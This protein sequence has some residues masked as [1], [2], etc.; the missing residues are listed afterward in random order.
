MSMSFSRFLAAA[1]ACVLMAASGVTFAQQGQLEEVVVTARMRTE[2]LQEVP[3]SVSAFT[4]DEIDQIGV[5]SMRD[6]AALVPN[7]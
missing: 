6:Y 1:A 4:A 7:M 3:V 2:S 5:A